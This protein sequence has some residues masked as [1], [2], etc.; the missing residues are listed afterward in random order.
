MEQKR[1]GVN[2][3]TGFAGHPARLNAVGDLPVIC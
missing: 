1:H 3:M 2:P